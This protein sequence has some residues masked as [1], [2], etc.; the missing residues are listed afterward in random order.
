MGEDGRRGLETWPTTSSKGSG[1][2]CSTGRSSRRGNRERSPDLE[3][4]EEGH[5]VDAFY[6]PRDGGRWADGKAAGGFV[7]A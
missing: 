6:S 3:M 4:V 7:G 1:L 2:L 5:G